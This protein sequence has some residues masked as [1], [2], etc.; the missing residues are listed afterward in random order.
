MA[1]LEI[2]C[3][4]IAA[5]IQAQ[6]G[7]ADRIELCEN[8]A[9]G[10]V[11]PS[12]AK[13]FLCKQ[14]LHIPVFV[15]IRPRPGDFHY[16][17]LEVACMLESIR[18]AK[19]LGADGIVA[20][21]LRADGHIDMEATKRLIE[22][23]APL[24]FTFH[25]AFD[26]CT[27]PIVALEQLIELGVDRILTSGQQASAVDGKT[28]IRELIYVAERRVTI[29]VGGGIRPNNIA[30]L[31]AIQGLTEFHSSAKTVVPS[32]MQFQHPLSADAAEWSGV[33]ASMV[34]FLKRKIK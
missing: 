9:Q 18:V 28:L 8:L 2:A 7:G 29:L 3:E 1:L 11:T 14:Q 20:G 6:S 10:G 21:A 23:A 5:A 25:R 26:R 16:D 34:R 12:S 27:D 4:T 15:L 30:H 13:I 31:T 19:E 33:S 24:P 22:S 17:S 32:R